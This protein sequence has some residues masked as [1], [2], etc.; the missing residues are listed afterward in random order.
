MKKGF[1]AQKATKFIVC[2]S[3]QIPVEGAVTD[4]FV[5]N[6]F[7]DNLKGLMRF[8]NARCHGNEGILAVFN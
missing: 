3:L 7:G 5:L 6:E 2:L 4:R 8:A 1:V